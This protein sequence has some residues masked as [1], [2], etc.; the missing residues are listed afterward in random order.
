MTRTDDD[1]ERET[2]EEIWE[3][4]E[5]PDGLVAS[6]GDPCELPLPT[7]TVTVDARAWR[8]YA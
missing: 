3:T 1:R 6:T 4:F 2:L 8:P 7:G 5:P